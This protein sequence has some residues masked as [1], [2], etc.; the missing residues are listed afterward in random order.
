MIQAGSPSSFKG[1]RKNPPVGLN[2]FSLAADYLG[3]MFQAEHDNNREATLLHYWRILKKRQLTVGLFSG[4]LMATV[5]VGTMAST[6]YFASTATLEISPNTPTV[7]S[8]DNVSEVVTLNASDERRA[9]YATQYRIL[10]SRSVI[11]EA[12]RRLQ[13]E[14]GITDFD[15]EEHPPKFFARH[16]DISPELDTRLVHVVVEYPDPEKAA[17]FANTL[18]ETYIEFNLQRALGTAQQAFGWLSEQQEVYRQRKFESDQ[19][20]HDF[21][22]KNRLDQGD[23]LKASLSKI[24]ESLS[25]THADRVAL[26]A[27]YNRVQALSRAKAW[28]GL[29]THLSSDSPVLQA[30]MQDLRVKEQERNELAATYLP[31]HPKMR[32]AEESLEGVRTQVQ[33]QVKR[34]LGGK[35]TQ[36]KLVTDQENA[37]AAEATSL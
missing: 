14:H 28:S 26:S 2:D 10:Q 7:L 17:L 6:P 9:Y 11:E 31:D 35:K 27:S 21:K 32:R 24:Q 8:G 30:L 34:W 5:A 20:V 25:A 19:E 16:L 36:L 37:L 1:D 3:Q 33:A 13:E 29:A 23:T 12:I 15:E 4:I 18:A 22:Y